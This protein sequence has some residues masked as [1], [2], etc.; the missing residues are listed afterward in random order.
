MHGSGS[1]AVG[2]AEYQMIEGSRRLRL[3]YCGR[4]EENET[5][6]TGRTIGR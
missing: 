2:V 1:Q 3:G 6:K 5:V 4:M